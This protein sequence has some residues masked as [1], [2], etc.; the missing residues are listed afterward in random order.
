MLS[1]HD[2]LSLETGCAR[3]GLGERLQDELDGLLSTEQQ[4]VSTSATVTHNE[5]KGQIRLVGFTTAS[6]GGALNLTLN[7][8]KLLKTS[9]VMV[10]IMN[11]NESA[12]LPIMS[13]YGIILA[14]GQLQVLMT[15]NGIGALG[16]GDDVIVNYQINEKM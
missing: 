15:N 9:S 5:R 8:S 2:K 14:D 16:A 13:L 7:N 3:K 1:K 10:T 11:L 4:V 12:G 6:G